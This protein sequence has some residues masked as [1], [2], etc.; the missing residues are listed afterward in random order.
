MA[1]PSEDVD[2]RDSVHLKP[3]SAHAI[4]I[5]VGTMNQDDRAF[6]DGGF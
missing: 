3:V 4:A 1:S 6:S 2:A 5:S